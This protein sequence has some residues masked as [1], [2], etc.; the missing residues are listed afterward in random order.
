MATQQAKIKRKKGNEGRKMEDSGTLTFLRVN[1]DLI[2]IKL[3]DISLVSA[4]SNYTA[5]HIGRKKYVLAN[6]LEKVLLKLPENDFVRI[7]RTY[8][9]RIDK[10]DWIRGSFCFVGRRRLPIARRMRSSVM[11]RLVIIEAP[12]K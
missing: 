4:V 1:H 12:K 11:Q 7:H 5:I 9:V 2:K 10:I 6:T 8:A 3:K